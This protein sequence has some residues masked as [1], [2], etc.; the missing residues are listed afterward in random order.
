MVLVCGAVGP[1][2]SPPLGY[3]GQSLSGAHRGD[4]GF[5]HELDK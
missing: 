1:L 4:Y 2:T 5:C 3:L